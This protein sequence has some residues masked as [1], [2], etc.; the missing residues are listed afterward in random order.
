MAQ[1]DGA[2]HDNNEAT[3][4]R[5]DATRESG[6]AT[7]H[8]GRVVR[9]GKLPN[10][11]RPGAPRIASRHLPR[12][13]GAAAPWLASQPARRELFVGQIVQSVIDRGG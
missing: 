13:T 4:A 10:A 6:C 1:L 5:T 9:E 8:L 12:K 11:G 2:L 7:D 3:L